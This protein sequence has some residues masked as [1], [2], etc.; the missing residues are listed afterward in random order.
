MSKDNKR[1]LKKLNSRIEEFKEALQ[2]E[3][4][5]Q[6]LQDNIP[7]SQVLI[8][9]EIFLPSQNTEEYVDG[10]FLYMNDVGEISNAEYY[11]RDLV[12]VEVVPLPDE[13]LEVVKDLF[14]DAFTLEV[15]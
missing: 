1:V 5:K 8:R 2:D 3:N 15:E 11:F 7:G 10:L 13:D 12:D 6:E 4:K 9:F 14:G